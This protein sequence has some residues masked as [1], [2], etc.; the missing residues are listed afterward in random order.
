MQV[1]KRSATVALGSLTRTFAPLATVVYAVITAA[2]LDD[3]HEERALWVGLL[4]IAVG[5]RATRSTSG[6]G[7]ASGWGLA[8]A[9]AALGAPA[10]A[11]PL[12]DA[13]GS[14]GVL[15]SA[16]G[17]CLAIAHV[18]GGDRFTVRTSRTMGPT[19]AALVMVWSVAIVASLG[20]GRRSLAWLSHH[21][22]F[23]TSAALLSTLVALVA[24]VER[25]LYRRRLELGIAERMRA[26]RMLFWTGLCGSSLVA[27][28]VMERPDG[29]ARLS[30][31]LAG[32]IAAAAA[33]HPD[34]IAVVRVARKVV[35]LALVGGSIALLGTAAVDGRAASAWILTMGTALACL[36]SS[37]LS[38]RVEAALRPAGGAWLDAFDRAS[39]QAS[40]PDPHDA[41]R[42][43]LFALRQSFGASGPSPE[44]WSFDPSRATSVDA[45]GYAH[46]REAELP[47]TL[48]PLASAEPYGALRAEA[49][50]GLQVRHPELRPLC[51]WMRDRGALL[52]VVVACGDEPEGLLVLPRGARREPVTLEEVVAAKRVADRMASASRARS[53]ELRLLTRAQTNIRRAEAAEH[54]V[55]RFEHERALGVHRSLLATQRLARP[56]TVGIYAATSRM[57][58]EALER[59][60]RAG[61]PI[62]VVAPGGVDAV[63]YL[64]RAH[65]AGTRCRGPFVLVDATSTREHDLARWADPQRSPLALAD[66]GMLVLLDVGA[67]PADVQQL[68]ARTCAESRAPWERPD[69]LDIQLAITTVC[70]PSDLVAAGRLD[71]ALEVRIGEAAQTPV[72]LPRLQDRPDDF[73]AILTDRLA[74]EGLRA[75]GRPLG[76]EP[77]AYARLAEYPFPGDDAELTVLVRRLVAECKTE[78]VCVGDLD[79]LVAVIRTDSNR[80]KDPLSA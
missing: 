41:I 64:A 38:S 46:E 36:C 17:A 28:F 9:I 7:R 11:S 61:A 79:G 26:A 77:S 52:A 47:A 56:A 4:A 55:E 75:R 69:R 42:V 30:L 76:I 73:R 33:L 74:R 71:P 1:A 20:P 12:L 22:L 21:P 59:R 32:C 66:R 39:D 13:C 3:G 48:L 70:E 62:V 80:R 27:V 40:H 19:I 72:A 35:G 44:L 51:S 63:S 50:E 54:Q 14:I 31:A 18:P 58:L 67:L 65:L 37:A 43:A 15:A 25:T 29:V 23:W 6:M 49:L 45:A 60:T 16:I 57:A 68:V 53:T 8:M 10:G 34:P 2:P 78:A 5:I 24:G